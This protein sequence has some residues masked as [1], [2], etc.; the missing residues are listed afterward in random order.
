MRH[1]RNSKLGPEHC[2][3]MGDND[4]YIH[5]PL[6]LVCKAPARN[7]PFDLP[8]AM[9]LIQDGA[10]CLSAV[11]HSRCCRASVAFAVRLGRTC[12]YRQ[13]GATLIPAAPPMA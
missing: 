6:M 3:P 9:S 10:G 12:S 2:K 7:Q 8:H 13:I 11:N 4:R 1:D 5:C